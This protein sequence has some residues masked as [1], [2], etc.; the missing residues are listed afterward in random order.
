[1]P[2]ETAAITSISSLHRSFSNDRCSISDSP[3]DAPS[4][5]HPGHS[6]KSERKDLLARRVSKA[7]SLLHRCLEGE[8]AMAHAD[9]SW[10]FA[11]G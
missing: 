7:R 9:V 1:M 3:A 6:K 4:E 2:V 10:G 11:L 8:G 5:R